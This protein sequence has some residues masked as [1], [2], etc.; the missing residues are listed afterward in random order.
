VVHTR[1]PNGKDW[2]PNGVDSV[3]VHLLSQVRKT[4]QPPPVTGDTRSED[5]LP[6]VRGRG[7]L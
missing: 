1:L 4:T 3:I 6:G 2:G 7:I 5:D